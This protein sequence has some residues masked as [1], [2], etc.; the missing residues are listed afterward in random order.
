[1]TQ[2]KNVFWSKYGVFIVGVGVI[3]IGIGVA[4]IASKGL[5]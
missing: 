1:M 4:I 5:I 3:S 2:N